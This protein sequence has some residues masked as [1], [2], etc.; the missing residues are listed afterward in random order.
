VPLVIANCCGVK[1]WEN[2]RHNQPIDMEHVR[3]AP[4]LVLHESFKMLGTIPE[5]DSYNLLCPKSSLPV[6]YESTVYYVVW[7][8]GVFGVSNAPTQLFRRLLHSSDVRMLC[9]RFACIVSTGD[10][11]RRRKTQN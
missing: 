1:K 3:G 10:G 8:P 11:I 9:K 6:K 7:H 4:R 2:S 5:T